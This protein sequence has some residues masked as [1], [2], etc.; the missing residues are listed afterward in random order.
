MPVRPSLVTL[1]LIESRHETSIVEFPT[2]ANGFTTVIEFDDNPPSGS[3]FYVVTLRVSPAPPAPPGLVLWNTL[4][5]DAEVLNSAFGPDLS[6]FNGGC[7]GGGNTA[8]VSGK[9]GNAATVALNCPPFGIVHNIVLE[10][11]PDHIDPEKGA[12]EVW[13]KQNEDPVAFSH[14]IYRIFGG[15]FGI[16][17]HH[18]FPKL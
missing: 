14:G 9:F 12:V 10:N 18:G 16:G 4:G 17:Q 15:G 3:A 11:L 7:D 8:Y 2:A 6:F 5:S 1:E 13:Y